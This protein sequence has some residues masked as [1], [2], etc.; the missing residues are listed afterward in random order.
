MCGN[1]VHTL[2]PQ[3][4]R[5]GLLFSGDQTLTTRTLR[6]L[7]TGGQGLFLVQ[8]S[9]E[10]ELWG[11]RDLEEQHMVQSSGIWTAIR[12]SEKWVGG[13]GL[14]RETALARR[15]SQ[16]RTLGLSLPLPPLFQRPSAPSAPR[17]RFARGSGRCRSL[18]APLRGG[19]V[20]RTGGAGR[21]CSVPWWARRAPRLGGSVVA[22]LGPARRSGGP[23]R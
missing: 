19:A 9:L 10:S 18:C 12:R 23:L 11:P 17:A 20:L 5:F 3:K 2:G 6:S 15:P 4:P 16:A 7:S 1:L 21:P 22:A 8:S 14:G 13:I